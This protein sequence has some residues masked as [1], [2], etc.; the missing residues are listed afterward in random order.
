MNHNKVSYGFVKEQILYFIFPPFVRSFVHLVHSF[1]YFANSILFIHSVHRFNPVHHSISHPLIQL[2][3]HPSVHISIHSS[4]HSSIHPANNPSIHLSVY[5][6]IH[7]FISY[8]SLYS[9]KFVSFLVIS[10]HFIISFI[11]IFNYLQA[12]FETFIPQLKEGKP[13]ASLKSLRIVRPG[14]YPCPPILHLVS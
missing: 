4:I 6:S 3:T 11:P 8:H 9:F 1:H 2:A 5:L 14:P 7:P 10:Y 13:L 12:Q